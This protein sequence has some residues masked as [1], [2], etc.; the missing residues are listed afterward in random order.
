LRN[1]AQLVE[2]TDVIWQHYP[3]C[4]QKLLVRLIASWPANIKRLKNNSGLAS[5]RSRLDDNGHGT[6]SYGRTDL[7]EVLLDETG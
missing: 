5:G 2:G 4:L 1:M 7:L 6:V 3:L